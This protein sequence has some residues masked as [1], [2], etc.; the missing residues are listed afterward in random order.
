MWR[1]ESKRESVLPLPLCLLAQQA[2]AGDALAGG[3][4]SLANNAANTFASSVAAGAIPFRQDNPASP[5]QL[6]RSYASV[7]GLLALLALGLFLLRKRL[8]QRL[9]DLLSTR[10]GL[11]C[12]ASLRMPMR[13]TVHVVS[14]RGREVMFVQ[15]GEGVKRL[16]EFEVGSQTGDSRT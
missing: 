5:L 15:C 7:L 2:L 1:S 9:P 14:W 3:A 12:V 13:T 11:H 4:G 6:G 16:S 8:G 10:T